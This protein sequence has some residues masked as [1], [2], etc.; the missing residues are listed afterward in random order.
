M[1]WII[2]VI[3]GLFEAGWAIG[4][5]YT[6]GLTRLF[7]FDEPVNIG[8]LLSIALILLEIT[9]PVTPD[10]GCCRNSDT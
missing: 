1:N 3:A 10:C 8:R 4:L 2:L 7:L 6:E 9:F 5:K